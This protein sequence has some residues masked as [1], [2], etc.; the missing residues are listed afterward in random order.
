MFGPAKS[1]SSARASLHNLASLLR[2]ESDLAGARPL[3]ERALAIREEVLAAA[4]C[5]LV[6]HQATGGPH[7]PWTKD[8]ARITADALAALGRA[9]EAVQRYARLS[10]KTG[11]QRQE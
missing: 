6:T 8:A 2:D 1:Y 4:E 7:H 11:T 10:I 9:D 5:A 3:C